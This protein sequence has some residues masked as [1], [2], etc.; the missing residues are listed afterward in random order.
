MG[1]ALSFLM[2]RTL[3]LHSDNTQLMDK[4]VH[5]Y[6]TGEFI[7]YG[8]LATKVG[9]IPGSFLTAVTAIPMK[10]YF[11]PYAAM[12]IVILFHFIY[13]RFWFSIFRLEQRPGF[14]F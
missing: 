3:M 10:I 11:H 13:F 4:A 8:N 6:Q 1:V 5:Y 7:H 9:S 12:S 2:M 14:L